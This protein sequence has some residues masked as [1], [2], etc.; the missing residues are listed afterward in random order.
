MNTK[1][2][3][4]ISSKIMVFSILFLNTIS[5]A[6]TNY[7]P[8]SE[9]SKDIEN[10]RILL[11]L[12]A[13]KDPYI[14]THNLWNQEAIDAARASKEPFYLPLILNTMSN[15]ISAF[16]RSQ[17]SNGTTKEEFNQ[18]AYSLLFVMMSYFNI[19]PA[20][21]S[22]AISAVRKAS[23]SSVLPYIRS[24]ANSSSTAD[25]R[26]ILSVS[27]AARR[28]GHVSEL[29][30]TI[31]NAKAKFRKPLHA[32]VQAAVEQI[33]DQEFLKDCGD[34]E[35]ARIIYGV[36]YKVFLLE[37]LQNFDDFLAD[38]FATAMN[39]LAHNTS[40][41]S[42]FTSHSSWKNFKSG[43]GYN[44]VSYLLGIIFRYDRSVLEPWINSLDEIAKKC[45]NAQ[46]PS[47]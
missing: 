41:E 39:E 24:I 4:I 11:D 9:E 46:D 23:L 13:K 37:M 17:E 18:Q 28:S 33:L 35:K 27:L 8:W 31:D 3:T 10:A 14:D 2:L 34:R 44:L 21:E 45:A 40:S 5:G 29:S 7:W 12:V 25:F 43:L 20:A 42:I 15:K 16:M 30:T 6:S 36:A 32:S 22:A 26:V 38:S 19:T 47:L 1:P